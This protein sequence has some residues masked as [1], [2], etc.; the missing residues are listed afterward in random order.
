MV[1]LIQRYKQGNKSPD[2]DPDNPYHYHNAKGEK[3]VITPEDWEANVGKPYFK[4]IEDAV[5][6]EQAAYP[7]PEYEVNPAFVRDLN[8]SVATARGQNGMLNYVG[9]KNQLPQ[10]YTINE[11]GIIF[12]DKGQAYVQES[13]PQ[14]ARFTYNTDSPLQFTFNKGKPIERNVN[15]YPINMDKRI[16]A[17]LHVDRVMNVNN[18]Y[19]QAVNDYIKNNT[20]PKKKIHYINSAFVSYLHP[21][22]AATDD[23]NDYDKAV[24]NARKLGYRVLENYKP[25]QFN[26]FLIGFDDNEFNEWQKEM[27]DRFGEEGEVYLDNTTLKRT[28]NGD[29]WSNGPNG[30]NGPMGYQVRYEGGAPSRKEAEKKAVIKVGQLQRGNS[31]FQGGGKL[32]LIPRA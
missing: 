20:T 18:E 21:E 13:Y 6:A 14:S 3:V 17:P 4:E 31:S 29:T 16:K 1:K 32:K 23:K 30:P 11:N 24:K 27:Y 22:I 8:N 25:G 5:K 10:G 26:S 7:G 2:H 9:Y 28:I 12:D 19:N 15:F